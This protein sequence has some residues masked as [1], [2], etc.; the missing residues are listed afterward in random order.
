MLLVVAILAAVVYGVIR[1]ILSSSGG[2]GSTPARPPRPVAPDD[3]PD[4]L[5]DLDRKRRQRDDSDS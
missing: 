1:L 5:R 4:F 3:D 2:T